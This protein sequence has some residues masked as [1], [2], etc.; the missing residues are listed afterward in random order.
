MR[1]LLTALCGGWVLAVSAMNLRAAAQISLGTGASP[2]GGSAAITN[3][4]SGAA[5]VVG[6]QYDVLYNGGRLAAN[7][8]VPGNA[9]LGHNVFL[10]RLT[11]NSSRVV[12]YSL[13][14]TAL[15]NGALASLY[16]A[17]AASA[18]LGTQTITLTN[19]ILAGAAGQSLG[20][21][22]SVPGNLVIT[23]GPAKLG[24]IV[25]S[26]EGFIQFQVEGSSGGTYLLQASTDLVSWETVGTSTAVAGLIQF[27]D[28]ESKTRPVRFYRALVK[29]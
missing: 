2:A 24:E 7:A 26:S 11:P 21:V 12:I 1:P 13:S 6:L 27:T 29:P 23:A 18:P 10:S 25:R 3:R 20:P 9:L 14:N 5:G 16:F 15:T 22:D 17:V 4:L 28:S 8:T 19:G